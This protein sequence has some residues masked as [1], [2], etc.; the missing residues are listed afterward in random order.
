MKKAKQSQ[1]KGKDIQAG[2]D[3][4]NQLAVEC[5]QILEN[6]QLFKKHPHSD[7]EVENSPSATI[8]RNSNNT[9][10]QTAIN[11]ASGSTSLN[12]ATVLN[13]PSRSVANISFST[14]AASMTTNSVVAYSS[15]SSAAA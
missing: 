1:K 12:N 15:L 3:T 8:N 13:V 5:L 2:K 11:S 7:V 10:V 9:A 14:A 4:E 6:V